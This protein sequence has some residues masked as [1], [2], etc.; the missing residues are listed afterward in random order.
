MLPLLLCEKFPFNVVAGL[1]EDKIAAGYIP[2]M[3]EI[4]RTNARMIK[5]FVSVSGKL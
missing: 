3:I 2:A 1:K 5:T 4:Q